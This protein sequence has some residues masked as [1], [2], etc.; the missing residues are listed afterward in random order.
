MRDT[1][2]DQ[3]LDR[4]EAAASSGSVEGLLLAYDDIS[5]CTHMGLISPIERYDLIA[6]LDRALLALEPVV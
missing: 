6:R 5:A 1:I 2:I 4:I 3:F